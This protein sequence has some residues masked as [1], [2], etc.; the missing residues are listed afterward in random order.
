MKSIDLAMKYMEIIYETGGIQ[1]LR[2]FLADDFLFEGPLN[3][4]H[5]AD[6]Y[7]SDMQ[8]NLPKK[9]AYKILNQYSDES[10]ACLIY[11]FSKPGITTMIA[12]TFEINSQNK[13]NKILL[14]FDTRP[15]N[16]SQNEKI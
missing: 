14:V 7:I 5:N 3:T 16:L 2:K 6:D 11:K 9:F 12:Q 4:Y 1:K 15:F 10:S 8:L 13:I